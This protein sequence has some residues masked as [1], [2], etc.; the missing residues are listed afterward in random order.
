MDSAIL[1]AI[2]RTVSIIFSYYSVHEQQLQLQTQQ[3]TP[4]ID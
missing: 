2:E 4:G 1:S 3:N